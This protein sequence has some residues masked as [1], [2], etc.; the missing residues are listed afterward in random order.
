MIRCADAAART[1]RTL[2][3]VFA[4][5]LLTAS[6]PAAADLEFPPRVWLNMGLYSSHFDR[7]RQFRENNTG[8]GAEALL[9]PEHAVMAGTFIN[10]QRA[11]SQYFAYQWRPLRWEPAGVGV[12]LG[13]LLGAFDGY[14]RYR[15]GGWF[16]APMPVLAI[17]GRYV[18]VNLSVV[19]TIRDRVD[20]AL[21]VQLKFR[22]W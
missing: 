22:I 5:F 14:P 9:A 16:V 1:A 18:G 13:I 4:W 11:R 10:S 15:D 7:G 8:F 12:N 20:G 17:E 19:P 3:R 2:P 21:A 6:C